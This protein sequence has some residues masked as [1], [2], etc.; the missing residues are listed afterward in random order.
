MR[1]L[2]VDSHRAY[3]ITEYMVDTQEDLDAIPKRNEGDTCYISSTG[4]HKILANVNNKL[5]WV[6]FLT[7]LTLLND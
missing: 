2:M 7:E 5:K 6:D 3:G 4:E 1:I